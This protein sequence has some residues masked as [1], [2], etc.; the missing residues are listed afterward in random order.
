M[1]VTVFLFKIVTSFSLSNY[2]SNC[3]IARVTFQ[4]LAWLSVMKVEFFWRNRPRCL[5]EITN[6]AHTHYF[7]RSS[8]RFVA[9]GVTISEF[10]HRFLFRENKLIFVFLSHRVKIFLSSRNHF[11]LQFVDLSSRRLKINFISIRNYS[12]VN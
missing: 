9:H 12:R 2:V 5:T 3:N 10:Y 7:V 11:F 4:T 8:V 6:Y 1:A